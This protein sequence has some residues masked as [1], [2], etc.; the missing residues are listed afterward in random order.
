M[1]RKSLADINCEGFIQTFRVGLQTLN[2][3]VAKLETITS[4]L[5]KTTSNL[6]KT[7]FEEQKLLLE[8]ADSILVCYNK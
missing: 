4:D 1:Y 7:Y 5:D 2:N 3:E 6:P 8:D